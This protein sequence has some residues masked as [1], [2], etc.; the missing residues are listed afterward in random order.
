MFHQ[1]LLLPLLMIATICEA[2]AQNIPYFTQSSGF[3]PPTG[4]SAM[5]VDTVR[6]ALDSARIEAGDSTLL[7]MTKV[8]SEFEEVERFWEMLQRR[9]EALSAEKNK[10]RAQALTLELTTLRG[11]VDST[12]ARYKQVADSAQALADRTKAL[13]TEAEEQR[14]ELADELSPNTEE[15]DRS[16][17]DILKKFH[18][19]REA[20]QTH[21]NALMMARTKLLKDPAKV[22]AERRAITVLRTDSINMLRDLKDER[23][24]LYN[25]M[26]GSIGWVQVDGHEESTE[27]FYDPFAQERSN[28]LQSN[29]L[30]LS[31][32]T[33][34]G[35]LYSEIFH[36]Y[37][38]PIRIGFG[39]LLSNATLQ[40]D[41]DTTAVD[42]ESIKEDQAQRVLGGGG[43]T[44]AI[45]ALPLVGYTSPGGTFMFRLSFQPK[46]AL[47][48]TKYNEDATRT[49]FHSDL[50]FEL[51]A[52][53]AGSNG[54][55]SFF[56]SVRPSILI[57]NP[58]FYENLQKGDLRSI[59]MAQVR[60][61]MGIGN[62]LRISY[63]VNAGDDF[64]QRTF[65]SQL[66]VTLLTS[67]LAGK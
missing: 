30:T 31:S 28:F 11:R 12:L 54:V 44:V 45:V 66:S 6:T 59:S 42:P 22:L 40:E 21:F 14:K 9:N 23:I 53:L 2:R 64:V 1:R 41:G 38:G 16:V 46:M 25:T 15:A 49:P 35:A 47:D 5:Q 50:G 20:T 61:G 57:G 17:Q 55:L 52:N 65:P 56:G 39:G 36:D 37:I 3:R 62:V 60:F 32:E 27:A 24:A 48:L 43:N 13:A 8:Q 33:G 19:Q 18:E 63:S 58:V 67:A 51:H 26:H 7:F 34:N 10:Q 4:P 29:I